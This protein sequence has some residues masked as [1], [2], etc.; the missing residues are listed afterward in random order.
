MV[1]R[2]S[3]PDNVPIETLNTY[4]ITLSKLVRPS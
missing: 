2:L 4:N 3:N 1:R